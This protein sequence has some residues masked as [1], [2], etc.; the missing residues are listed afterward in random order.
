MRKTNAPPYLKFHYQ[1]FRYVNFQI[2]KKSRRKKSIWQ[3]FESLSLKGQKVKSVLK[4]HF[5]NISSSF[6][7]TLLHK[8]LLQENFEWIL[9]MCLMGVCY[10][11]DV[12][13]WGYAYWICANWGI[14][15]SGKVSIWD[16]SNGGYVD[17]GMRQLGDVAIGGFK[18]W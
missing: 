3:W 12:R 6:W 14:C 10:I 2:W 17:W 18:Y 4:E 8:R 1:T 9:E 11:P 16:V 7:P 13:I 15:Y 5:L